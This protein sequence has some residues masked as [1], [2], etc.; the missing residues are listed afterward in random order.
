MSFRMGSKKTEHDLDEWIRRLEEDIVVLRAA[1]RDAE[2]AR[3][4]AK[5]AL[6]EA[7]AAVAELRRARRGPSQLVH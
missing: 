3:A 7:L 6:S 2:A 5:A 4:L 1:L